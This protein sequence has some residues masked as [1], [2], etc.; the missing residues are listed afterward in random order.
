MQTSKN[1]KIFSLVFSVL[2]AYL[3]TVFFL[4]ILAFFMLKAGV[5]G[6]VVNVG[7][8]LTYVLSNFVGGFFMGKRA[9]SKK[10][11]WGLAAAGVYFL[12]YLV[13]AVTF[14]SQESFLSSYI[15]SA[16]WMLLG[17][18]LGGMLS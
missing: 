4:L 3:V 15:S 6:T 7:I 10:Y 13:L 8:I 16:A 5:S 12:I 9:D 2:A 11:L 1:N 17:G 14:G 18:V